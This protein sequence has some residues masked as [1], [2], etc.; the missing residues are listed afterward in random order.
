MATPDQLIDKGPNVKGPK[1]A[2]DPPQLVGFADSST[3][4]TGRP[5][6]RSA[7]RH[8][9]DPYRNTPSSVSA[10]HQGK[11]P[12]GKALDHGE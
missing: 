9:I 1:V 12:R 8:R 4:A 5:A 11:G 3:T 6:I 10:P 2:L 7:R